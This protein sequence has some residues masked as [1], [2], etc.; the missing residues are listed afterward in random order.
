MKDLKEITLHCV[1][2]NATFHG[3]ENIYNQLHNYNRENIKRVDVNRKRLA[4]AFFLNGF[5]EFSYRSG[6][7]HEFS[8]DDAW[9]DE[10]ILE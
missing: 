9:L 6:I 3:L 8:C 10:T 1:H 2:N 7:L 4:T 5:L